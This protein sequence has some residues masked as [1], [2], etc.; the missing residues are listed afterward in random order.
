MYRFPVIDIEQRYLQH[1]PN[2]DIEQIEMLI[3]KFF[4]NDTL[5]QVKN[6][7]LDVFERIMFVANVV[8]LEFPIVDENRNLYPMKTVQEQISEWLTCD[9]NSKKPADC[10]LVSL[11]FAYILIIHLQIPTALSIRI[12]SGHPVVYCKPNNGKVYRISFLKDGPDIKSIEDLDGVDFEEVQR[13]KSIRHYDIFLN[14]SILIWRVSE[15]AVL[16]DFINLLR[17]CLVNLPNNPEKYTKIF[18]DLV[19]NLSNY[20]LDH[21]LTDVTELIINYW[22]SEKNRLEHIMTRNAGNTDEVM[23]I[24]TCSLRF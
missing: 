10:K 18:N 22:E 6:N 17:R 5:T 23:S 7:N 19:T 3:Q 21:Q 11:I 16:L 2:I 9:N 15:A 8:N 1:N 20:G 24:F 13:S 14:N 4:D 12:Y